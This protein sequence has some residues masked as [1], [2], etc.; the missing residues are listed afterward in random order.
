MVSKEIIESYLAD[1][2]AV[3]KMFRAYHQTYH[4][5]LGSEETAEDVARQYQFLEKSADKFIEKRKEE[6]AKYPK[7]V[8]SLD[9]VHWDLYEGLQTK[10]EIRKKWKQ[11]EQIHFLHKDYFS[12]DKNIFINKHM[13]FSP[14]DFH[15]HEFIEMCYIYRGQVT[16]TFRQ[17]KGAEEKQE[18]LQ[19]G[20][21]VIIPPG[22]QH[23]LAIYDDSVM[24]NIVV[25]KYTFEKTFLGDI[26]QNSL[27]YQFFSEILFSQESGTYIV[28]AGGEEEV[29]RDK[30]LDLMVAYLG[31]QVYGSKICD[32][33]LSIFFLELLGQC[34]NVKLSSSLGKEG[35]QIAKILIYIR[36]HYAAIS[37]EEVAEEFHYSKTYLNR[38]FKK[39]MGTTILKYIQETRLEESALLLQNTRMAVDDIALRVGYEDTSYYIEIFKKKYKKTPLQ[40]RHDYI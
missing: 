26:P 33:Y 19:Q 18:T 15:D 1:Y 7:E 29:L 34:E 13:R 2:S 16:H 14:G 36:N 27:L 37:L 40:Y 28:F 9:N 11:E 24:I 20:N 4:A 25:N 17:K 6:E 5:W 23:C 10:E 31:D 22:M 12:T 35:D 21:L 8:L 32:H 38:I 3:E 39:H 30:L